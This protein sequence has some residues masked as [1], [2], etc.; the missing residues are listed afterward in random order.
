MT[1]VI[2]GSNLTIEKL[3]QVARNFEEIKLHPDAIKRIKKCRDLLDKK[4]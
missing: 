3:V 2:D 4:D 1:I